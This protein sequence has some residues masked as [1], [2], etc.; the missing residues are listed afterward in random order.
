MRDLGEVTSIRRALACCAATLVVYVGIVH[1]VVGT[2]LYP[3]GPIVLGGP[4]GWHAVGVFGIVA[5][6]AL[7]AGALRW[8]PV[9][10]V[11]LAIAVGVI[12]AAIFVVAALLWGDFHFFA[13]TVV[14]AAAVLAMTERSPKRF[15]TSAP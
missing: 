7:V 13:F 5:G 4:L 6:L 14:V 12:G 10:V 8:L 2:R 9:P 3:D 11:P 15:R 1:E